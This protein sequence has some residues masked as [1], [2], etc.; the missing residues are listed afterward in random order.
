MID[1]IWYIIYHI[2]YIIYHT[3]YILHHI[4]DHITLWKVA[5]AECFQTEAGRWEPPCRPA[6]PAVP[7]QH[8][9]SFSDCLRVIARSS[10]PWSFETLRASS[11]QKRPRPAGGSRCPAS[12]RPG[13][14]RRPRRSAGRSADGRWETPRPQRRR[15]NRLV[16]QIKFRLG[17]EPSFDSGLGLQFAIPDF[18]G[19]VYLFGGFAGADRPGL[20]TL[21]S[22]HVQILTLTDAQTPSLGTPLLP[23]R[24]VIVV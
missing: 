2:S 21:S 16:F 22:L 7:A 15:F 10:N 4:S 3:S 18:I 24:V 12:R 1:Y 17:L 23:L 13:P 6:E 9:G 14:G 20:V 19:Q 5:S 8:V 11:A